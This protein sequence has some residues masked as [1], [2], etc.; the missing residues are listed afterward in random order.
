MPLCRSGRSSRTRHWARRATS[1]WPRRWSR[2]RWRWSRPRRLAPIRCSLQYLQFEIALG[3][4]RER[5]GDRRLRP[6]A[7]LDPPWPRGTTPSRY[8]RATACI[9]GRIHDFAAVAQPAYDPQRDRRP[10]RWPSGRRTSTTTRACG[11]RWPWRQT[12]LLPILHPRVR[13]ATARRRRHHRRLRDDAQLGGGQRP[14]DGG[15]SSRRGCAARSTGAAT[16]APGRGSP[17][18][19][20]PAPAR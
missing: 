6:R 7:R 19:S 3:T 9:Q 15:D 2:T 11:G 1:R 8:D 12:T 20:R 14:P 13:C 17:R 16:H 4:V 18:C 5:H 10:H